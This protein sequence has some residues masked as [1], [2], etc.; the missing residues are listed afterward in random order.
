MPYMKIT[1]PSLI[2]LGFVLCAPAHAVETG[3]TL[4]KAVAK[5]QQDT[6]GKVLSAQTRTL[7]HG[8]TTEYRLKVLTPDGH[9]R[10][11]PVRTETAKIPG[12]TPVDTKEKH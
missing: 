2:F 5:V 12:A 8:L 4:E 3:L 7:E 9:V 10:V 11:V 6:G 1:L